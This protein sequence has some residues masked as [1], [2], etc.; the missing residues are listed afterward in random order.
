[1]A[2]KSSKR[3]AVSK[4][5]TI[6]KR[7]KTTTRAG[8]PNV[9]PHTQDP[10]TSRDELAA[11]RSGENNHRFVHKISDLVE[12]SDGSEIDGEGPINTPQR[13]VSKH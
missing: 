10:D 4:P 11:S 8:T 7:A 12:Q 2:S 5:K 13:R 1:M 3:K 9:A 6:S